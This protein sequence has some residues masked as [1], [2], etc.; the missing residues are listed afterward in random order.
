MKKLIVSGLLVLLLL[1]PGCEN[2]QK[3]AD[4]YSFEEETF[5][6]TELQV[7]VVLVQNQAEM[8][9]LLQQVGGKVAGGREVAAFATLGKDAPTCTIYMID[10]NVDYQ[11]EWIGHEFTHCVFG[12]WHDVQQ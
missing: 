5:T 11:P 9:R 4:G 6:R 8:E 12:E 3:S 2:R 7:K 10:P 1:I